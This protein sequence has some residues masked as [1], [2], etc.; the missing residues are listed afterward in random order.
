[1]DQNAWKILI[2]DDD[3]F[4]FHLVREMLHEANQGRCTLEWAPSFKAGM[5]ALE[6]GAFEAVLVDYFLGAT[7]GLDLIWAAKACGFDA[8]FIL[9]TG[10]GSHAVDV[11]AM[12][13]GASLYLSKDEASPSL[14]ERAIRYAI[15]HHQTEKVLRGANAELQLELQ[16]RKKAERAEQKAVE[17]LREANATLEE[18]VAERTQALADSVVQLRQEMAENIRINQALVESEARLREALQHE[19]AMRVQLIQAEK[20]AA[21]ARMVA[22]VAHELN[23]PIQTILNSLYLVKAEIP[24]GSPSEK[25]L[26]MAASEA[27]RVAK[28]VE[29][30]RE[31]YR[32]DRSTRM[33]PF[34]L[35]DVLRGV[36]NILEPHLR[37]MHS[38]LEFSCP[39]EFITVNGIPDRIKQVCLNIC[40]NAI[41]AMQPTGGLLEIRVTSLE[42]SRQIGIS[43]RDHGPG[44]QP[45]NLQRVFEPFF[46][47]KPKGTGLGLPICYEIMQSHGGS[48]TLENCPDEGVTFNVWMPAW[49]R[50]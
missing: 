36:Q 2:V 38:R 23:N 12:Q 39:S 49:K 3:E 46:T 18:H 45:E 15:E 30:L 14:L 5:E 50:S 37:Q 9:F 34:N 48:I 16:R 13:A 47:T 43:F 27:R 17:A 42:E 1:M 10:R 21:L 20:F 31:T 26:E 40:L 25:I 22:S 29:Q 35:V 7:T 19:Q 24:Q 33:E 44:I 28:L 6:K 8:P 4:D 41:E 11:E 32:P